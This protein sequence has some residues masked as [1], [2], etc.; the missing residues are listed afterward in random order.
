[1]AASVEG[2]KEGTRSCRPAD[3]PRAAVPA[4]SLAEAA[5]NR[6][7]SWTQERRSKREGSGAL[8]GRKINRY[9]YSTHCLPLC[10]A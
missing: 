5:G 4:G 9:N 1:M 10:L 2:Q 3:S 6:A 7:D 8:H